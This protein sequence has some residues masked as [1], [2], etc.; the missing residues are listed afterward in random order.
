[1]CSICGMI[2][3]KQSQNVSKA[4]VQEMGKVLRHRG[5]D[6]NDCYV[7]ENVVFQHNRLAV[8]D[9]ANGLQPM[10]CTYEGREYVIVYNGEIYNTVELRR[11]IEKKGITLLS[12]IQKLYFIYIFYLKKTV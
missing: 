5:P 3:F 9:I 7:G 1:M 2:D 8:I 6:Q 4:L 10:K 12:V 11:L